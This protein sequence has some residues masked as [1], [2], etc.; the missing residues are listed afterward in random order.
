MK[1]YKLYLMVGFILFIEINFL[2]IGIKC[3]MWYDKLGGGWS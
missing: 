3:K 1:Q 2:I